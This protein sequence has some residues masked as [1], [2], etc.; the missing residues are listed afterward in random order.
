MEKQH[1][2]E[3]KSFI[4]YELSPQSAKEREKALQESANLNP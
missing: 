3:H 1:S 4:H 2:Q